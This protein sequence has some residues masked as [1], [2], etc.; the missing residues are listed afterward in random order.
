MR[1]H[2]FWAAIIA[3]RRHSEEG[4]IFLD[5]AHERWGRSGVLLFCHQWKA[6][7]W[8]IPLH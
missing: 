3:H 8:G 2:C 6:V 1:G 7:M 5:G 4:S